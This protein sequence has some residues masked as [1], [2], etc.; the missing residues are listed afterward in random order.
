M[1]LQG[2]LEDAFW[3]FSGICGIQRVLLVAAAWFRG[4]L[5]SSFWAITKLLSDMKYAFRFGY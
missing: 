5:S 4:M 2:L 3:G 1:G